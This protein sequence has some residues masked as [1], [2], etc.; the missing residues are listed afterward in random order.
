MGKVINLHD[1]VNPWREALALD[2]ENSTLQIYINDTSGHVEIVQMN[3]DGEAIR[4]QLGPVD[5]SLLKAAL[6]TKEK[7]QQ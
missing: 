2:S 1:Y 6:S 3:D 7:Q 5:A 4:S